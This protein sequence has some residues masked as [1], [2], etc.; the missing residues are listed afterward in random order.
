MKINV[1]E[2]NFKMYKILWL[3]DFGQQKFDNLDH[4]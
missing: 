3:G 4:P 2:V 1:K